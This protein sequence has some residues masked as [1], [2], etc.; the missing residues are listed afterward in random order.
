MEI[1]SSSCFDLDQLAPSRPTVLNSTLG[2][3]QRCDAQ[4]SL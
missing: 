1:D 3:R 4:R 2:F